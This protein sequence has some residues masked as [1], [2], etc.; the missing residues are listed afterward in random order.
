MQAES[1]WSAV[2][3]TMSRFFGKPYRL[4]VN[5]QG[6][7]SYITYK[8]FPGV[9]LPWLAEIVAARKAGK[10]VDYD[11]LN[12]KIGNAI[13]YAHHFN[14]DKKVPFHNFVAPIRDAEGLAVYSG[15]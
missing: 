4:P 15:P 13:R 10:P 6:S 8:D 3:T 14:P 12:S 11:L 5:H 7:S 1:L 9:N 2:N